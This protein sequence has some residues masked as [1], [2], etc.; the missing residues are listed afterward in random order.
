MDKRYCHV[1]DKGSIAEVAIAPHIELYC[2]EFSFHEFW[3]KIC[4]EYLMTDLDFEWRSG[5][6]HCDPATRVLIV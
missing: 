5:Q 4:S 3:F 2:I 1:L 6:T